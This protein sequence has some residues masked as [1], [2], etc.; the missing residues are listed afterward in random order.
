M[1]RQLG[2]ATRSPLP[3]Q[4]KLRVGFIMSWK[5]KTKSQQWQGPTVPQTNSFTPCLQETT[6]AK[7]WLDLQ[8]C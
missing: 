4:P 6:A 8:S 5:V 7:I 2:R 3:E 1:G